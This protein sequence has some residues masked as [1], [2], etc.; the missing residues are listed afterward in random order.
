VALRTYKVVLNGDDVLSISTAM[1]PANWHEM[2]RF[3]Q[4]ASRIIKT[5]Y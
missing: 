4:A 5:Y 1:P 3:R 2:N